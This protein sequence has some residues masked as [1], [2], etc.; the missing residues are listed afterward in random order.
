MPSWSPLKQK[1]GS[2]G[3]GNQGGKAPYAFPPSSSLYLKDFKAPNVLLTAFCSQRPDWRGYFSYTFI[4][5]ALLQTTQERGLT[6]LPWSDPR[7]I[8]PLSSDKTNATKDLNNSTSVWEAAQ[9]RTPSSEPPISWNW[10]PALLEGEKP[11][12]NLPP[13]ANRVIFTQDSWW[14]NFAGTLLMWKRIYL[15]CSDKTGFGLQLRVHFSE[16]FKRINK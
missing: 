5:N 16:S 12:L 8:P 4:R 10:T 2:E 6:W 14:G 9:L 7:R 1:G 13:E 15:V 3:R 11:A